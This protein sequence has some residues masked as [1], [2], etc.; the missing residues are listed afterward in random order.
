MSKKKGYVPVVRRNGENGSEFIQNTIR[1]P[2]HVYQLLRESAEKAG[3]SLHAE[4]LQRVVSSLG[5]DPLQAHETNGGLTMEE[6]A[7]DIKV[8]RLLAEQ[9]MQRSA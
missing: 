1:F 6:M 3:R 8:L 5:I 2:P 4:I 7:A 9:F